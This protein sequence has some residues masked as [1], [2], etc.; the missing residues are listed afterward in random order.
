MTWNLISKRTVFLHRGHQDIQ[1]SGERVL[2]ISASPHPGE[3]VTTAAAT[4]EEKFLAITFTDKIYI[5]DR[6][7]HEPELVSLLEVEKGRQL[8]RIEFAKSPSGG[9]DSYILVSDSAKSFHSFL[10]GRRRSG[11]GTLTIKER[12][13]SP[14][15]KAKW[16]CQGAFLLS[17]RAVSILL[18]IYCSLL[19]WNMYHILKSLL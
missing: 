18:G 17:H 15:L 10:E 11:D 5:F 6:D 12:R 4:P 19:A 3:Q 2:E 7:G 9:D 8:A 1:S 13:R 16:L 14:G